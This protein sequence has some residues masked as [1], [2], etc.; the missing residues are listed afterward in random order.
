MKVCRLSTSSVEFA[1]RLHDFYAFD[2]GAQQGALYLHRYP[3][4]STP[5][6]YS[7][8]SRIHIVKNFKTCGFARR[9]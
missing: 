1:S 7:R 6:A 2:K 5:I 3:T 9:L 8:L 4:S